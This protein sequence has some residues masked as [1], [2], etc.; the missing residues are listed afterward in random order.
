MKKTDFESRYLGSCL[1]CE[2][3]FKLRFAHLLERSQEISEVYA[4][5]NKCK[6]STLIY[7]ISHDNTV[8][9]IPL[10]TDM[11]KED[12]KRFRAMTHMTKDEVKHIC[13]VL[14]K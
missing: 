14:D 5:C 3:K 11:S 6:S 1:M 12:A 7:I 4:G 10:L 9:V 8:N 13:N 2:T